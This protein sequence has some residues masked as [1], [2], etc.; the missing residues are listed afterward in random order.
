MLVPMLHIYRTCVFPCI[1]VCKMASSGHSSLW[2]MLFVVEKKKDSIN[3]KYTFSLPLN[4]KDH[5]HKY[6][7]HISYLLFYT[8]LSLSFC[9]STFS[10]WH[11]YSSCH[12]SQNLR[13]ILCLPSL[14]QWILFSVNVYGS[15]SC[16]YISESL[17][18]SIPNAKVSFIYSSSLPPTSK[19]FLTEPFPMATTLQSILC[20]RLDLSF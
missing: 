3:F 1:C 14:P 12:Q 19:N 10:K 6:I 13:V 11:H 15:S 9:S 2:M 5:G 20:I 8:F 17:Q 16:V 18:L 4:E 7:L